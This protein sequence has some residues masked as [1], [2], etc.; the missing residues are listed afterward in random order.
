MPIFNLKKSTAAAGS[1]W[2]NERLKNA[3]EFVLNANLDVDPSEMT[4]Q[5][6]CEFWA[7]HHLDMLKQT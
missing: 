1:G 3:W 5:Q 7:Q 2:N 6:F 4:H